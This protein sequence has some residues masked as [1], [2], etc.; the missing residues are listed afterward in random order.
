LSSSPSSKCIKKNTSIPTY[1]AMI[2]NYKEKNSMKF[3]FFCKDYIES[4]FKATQ[5]GRE[6]SYAK[7]FPIVLED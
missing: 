3:N 2:D 4:C 5:D 6:C 7:M 1:I